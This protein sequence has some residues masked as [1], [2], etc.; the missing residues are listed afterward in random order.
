MKKFIAL[1]FVLAFVCGTVFV[2][3]GGGGDKKAA[4][5][6]KTVV[7]L[8]NWPADTLPGDIAMHQEWVK[9]FNQKYPDVIIQPAYYFYAVDTFVPMAEAG[10]APTVF[11]PWFTEPPKLISGGFV[12]DVTA[13]VKALGWDAKM[14]D[15]VKSI[16]SRDGK[17]YGVPRDAYA[18]GL[19]LNVELF[20]QAGL[21][22][23]NG[24]PK[25]PKTWDE[26]AETAR[27]IKEKTGS[28]GLCLLAKD[29]AGGWHFTNIAWG[30]G[31]QFEVQRNG[32][33]AAQINTPEA[34]AAMN[35]VKDLRWK[36]DVL[37]ADPTNEDW[38][39]GFQQLGTGNAAMYIAAQDAVNQPTQV[40]GL[41]VGDL[42]LVPIPA[43]PKGRYSLMGGTIYMFAANAAPAEVTA[44]LHYLEIMGKGPVVNP[45]TVAGLRADAANRKNNGIP[46]LPSFPAWTD[47]ALL[48]AQQDAV[49]EYL[50]VDM[51]LYND[52]Y[53]AVAGADNLRPEEPQAAQDLYAEL[54]KVLQAVITD[55]NANVQAL[56][57]AAQANFQKILDTA[58]NQ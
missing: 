15:S 7:K 10:Q 29:N 58:V 25:Y 37:T 28:A 16:L 1:F 20:R 21:T 44:A 22:D 46:V 5:S 8:G 11:E 39:T 9:Q 52:Y 53:N 47:P 43:G 27:T 4:E 38:G 42:A 36:Y 2:F 30:F 48:K 33:W 23:N 31:A 56:L 24:L 19:M 26:L 6:G 35:Y 57:D 18:L 54:T 55:R 45:D 50:N 49:N 41:P 14:N 3:A 12:K 32:K 40:N 13:E 34:A 51:R 17:L